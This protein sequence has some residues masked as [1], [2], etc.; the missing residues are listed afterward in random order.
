MSLTRSRT[1]SRISRNS[2]QA[3]VKA[4]ELLPEG[5]ASGWPGLWVFGGRQ[6]YD[7]DILTETEYYALDVAPGTLDKDVQIVERLVGAACSIPPGQSRPR[8][9]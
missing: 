2:G 4:A 6:D 7:T 1:S 3:S 9:A 8:A 5:S